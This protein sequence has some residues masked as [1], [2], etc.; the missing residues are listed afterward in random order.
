MASNTATPL[1]ARSAAMLVRHGDGAEARRSVRSHDH[2]CAQSRTFPKL[3]ATGAVHRL[4]RRMGRHPGMS[5][6]L[7]L[8]AMNFLQFFVWGAWLITIGAYWFQNRALVG[9]AVRRDLLH[10][11]HRL[12]VHALGDRHD[13]RQVDQR[14]KALRPAPHRGAV[15]LFI[16]PLVDNPHTLFWVMLLNMCCYMPT[17]SLAITVAYNALKQERRGRGDACI[18]RSACGAR[19]VSSWRLGR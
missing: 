11:G 15:V 17:I 10:H 3:A 18:R 9:H 19:S 12:A 2:P 8:I 5:L 14:G 4:P 16:V 13:R 1:P 7:R 6:K